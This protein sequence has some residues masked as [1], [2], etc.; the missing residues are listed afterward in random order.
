MTKL[1]SAHNR[2]L[3]APAAL[4]PHARLHDLRHLHATTLLF[5]GVPVHV[6][7][8]RL[9]HADLA[10]TLRVYSHVLREHTLGVGDVFAQAVTASVGN[11]PARPAKMINNARLLQAEA[12]VNLATVPYSGDSDDAGAVVHGID[13]AVIA[14][15]DAKV[16]PMASQRHETRRLWI[17]AKPP[18][19]CAI[20]S[21]MDRSS[22]R[23]ERR[24]R[25]RTSIV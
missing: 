18:M 12:P 16:R 23:N 8:A 2:W 1:I 19:T 3:T 5:P 22:C 15:A 9:G 11:P 25:G 24:A 7:A 20:V 4:L 17:M 6:V 14:G 10:V 13:H 21:R